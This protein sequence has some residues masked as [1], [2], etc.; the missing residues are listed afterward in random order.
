MCKLYNYILDAPSIVNAT[1]LTSRSVV[2][3]WTPFTS[4]TNYTGYLISYTTNASYTTGGS[5]MVD[6]VST[7]S[8]ILTN[9]E[10]STLYT[11]TVQ[12]VGDNGVFSS[13]SS[14]VSTATYT[15]GM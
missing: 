7:M 15:D 13:N 4:L 12:G 11:T 8:V 3:T 6:G 5:V 14:E 10:E 2:V 9:L 1:T